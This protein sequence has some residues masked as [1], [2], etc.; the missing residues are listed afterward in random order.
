MPS[1]VT[2]KRVLAPPDNSSGKFWEFFDKQNL[3][4]FPH[5]DFGKPCFSFKSAGAFDPNKKCYESTW[6]ITKL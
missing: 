5:K 3:D 2:V 4:S 6:K 1:H